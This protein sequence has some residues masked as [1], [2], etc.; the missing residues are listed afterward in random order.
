MTHDLIMPRRDEPVVDENGKPT[1]R[2]SDYLEENTS[3]TTVV[4]AESEIST[5]TINLS[6]GK[7]AE[8]S[9]ALVEVENSVLAS[10]PEKKQDI[11]YLLSFHAKIAD[12][13]NQ[14]NE[15]RALVN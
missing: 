1:K 3:Q 8:T 11:E 13:Q 4:V 7:N 2:F 15:L 9:K 14:I 12:L 6:A 10:V 5:E